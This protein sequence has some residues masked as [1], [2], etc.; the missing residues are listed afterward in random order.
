MSYPK[1]GFVEWY[2]IGYEEAR[3]G[4]LTLVRN[5][6]LSSLVPEYLT[7]IHKLP[8]WDYKRACHWPPNSWHVSGCKEFVTYFSVQGSVGEYRHTLPPPLTVPTES[9]A[10]C[11][12]P[13]TACYMDAMQ[14]GCFCCPEHAFAHRQRTLELMPHVAELYATYKF[15]PLHFDPLK[16]KRYLQGLPDHF[17]GQLVDHSPINLPVV[18]NERQISR[19]VSTGNLPAGLVLEDE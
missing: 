6:S 11:R 16:L 2:I 3:L 17:D 1:F 10:W 4:Y 7:G 15:Q 13:A 18:V 14:D 5:A 19:E 8:H 9:C 12:R